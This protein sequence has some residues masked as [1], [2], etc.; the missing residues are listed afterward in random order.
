MK[1]STTV[2][3]G[4]EK[5]SRFFHG[6]IVEFNNILIVCFSQ[7]KNALSGLGPRVKKALLSEKLLSRLSLRIEFKALRFEKWLIVLIIWLSRGC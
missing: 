6:S 4:G 5:V 3:C 7:R 1:H 2:V